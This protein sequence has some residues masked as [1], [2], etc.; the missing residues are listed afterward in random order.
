MP[1]SEDFDDCPE[2]QFLQGWVDAITNDLIMI[3]GHKEQGHSETEALKT[4]GRI[5]ADWHRDYKKLFPQNPSSC[6]P[7]SREDTEQDSA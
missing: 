7:Y 2:L 4:L 1:K 5:I 6:K 3:Q